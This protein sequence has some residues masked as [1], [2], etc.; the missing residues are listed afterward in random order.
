MAYIDIEIDKLT[1]SIENVITG[2]IFPTEILSLREPEGVDFVIE[3]HNVTE[4]DHLS[5]LA[6]ISVCKDRKAEQERKINKIKRSFKQ[7]AAAL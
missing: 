2:D 6:F 1:H 3:P 4:E 7:V 5:M